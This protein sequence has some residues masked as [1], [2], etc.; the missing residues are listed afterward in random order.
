MYQTKTDG[1]SHGERAECGPFSTFSPVF[2]DVQVDNMGEEDGMILW[3]IR[4]DF[5]SKLPHCNE[6]FMPFHKCIQELNRTLV[7]LGRVAVN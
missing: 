6:S 4:L 3:L 1:R 2:R 5:W 7:Q